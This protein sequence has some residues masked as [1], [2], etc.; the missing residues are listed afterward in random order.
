VREVNAAAVVLNEKIKSEEVR[1][2]PLPLC[3]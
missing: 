3:N 2:L 1:P